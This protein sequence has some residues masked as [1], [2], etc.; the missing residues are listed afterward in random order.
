MSNVKTWARPPFWTL[1]AVGAM[2]ST[3]Y[4]ENADVDATPIKEVIIAS[5]NHLDVGFTC[6]VP[7]LMRRLIS[8]DVNG[9]AIRELVPEL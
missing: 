7:E 3:A 9:T 2:M 8:Y 6:T 5:K 4:A 1:I